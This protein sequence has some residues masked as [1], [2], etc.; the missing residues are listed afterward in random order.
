MKQFDFRGSNG[1]CQKS[2]DHP[3]R[4]NLGSGN[5]VY[6][7]IDVFLVPKG[8]FLKSPFGLFYNQFLT[9]KICEY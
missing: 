1:S 8:D 9:A 4:V 5:D 6:I 7:S 3:F 2:I